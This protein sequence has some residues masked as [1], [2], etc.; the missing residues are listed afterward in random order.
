MK[1]I[2]IIG[3]ILAYLLIGYTITSIM[4]ALDF[5]DWAEDPDFSLF[6]GTLIWPITIVPLIVIL[7]IAK[8]ISWLGRKIALY[9]VSIA[10]I[11]K[12]MIERRNEKLNEKLN[13]EVDIR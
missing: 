10:L 8:I 2:L 13:E 5:S 3:L 7:I 9:P 4:I 6:V 12:T 1:V 11:I